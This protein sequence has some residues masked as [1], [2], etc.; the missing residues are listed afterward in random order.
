MYICDTKVC[1]KTVD[2]LLS[3]KIFVQNKINLKEENIVVEKIQRLQKSQITF[4]QIL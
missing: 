1:W 3:E 4:S 2:L